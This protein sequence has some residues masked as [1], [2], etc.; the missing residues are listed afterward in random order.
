M[1][2]NIKT[3]VMHTASAVDVAAAQPQPAVDGAAAAV[4]QYQA[5]IGLDVGDRQSHYCV[6][7]LN[8]GVVAE[9]AVKTTEASLRVQFEGKGRMRRPGSGHPFAVDQSPVDRA[10]GAS[11]V[12]TTAYRY[13]GAIEEIGLFARSE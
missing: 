10:G 8:G 12:N 7:D 9:G 1:K 6:L 2:K 11:S 4:R 13:S 3:S 5:V